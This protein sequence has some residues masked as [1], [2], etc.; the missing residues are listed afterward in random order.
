ML[1]FK[2]AGE[3]KLRENLVMKFGGLFRDGAPGK[4]PRYPMVVYKDGEDAIIVRD[5]EAHEAAKL[6]GFDHITAGQ[7][8]NK[9]LVNWFWD[10]EDL[11]PRQL[12]VFAK[13]EYDVDL[14]V[15][16]GQEKLFQ[17]VCRLTKAAPQNRSRITLMAHSIKMNYD[18]TLEE[19]R[20]MVD[21]TGPD[22][23]IQTEKWEITA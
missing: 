10:L 9:N 18:E 21:A 7:M 20:R 17:C 16:C 8:Q 1:N 2:G 4:R 11:S 19:I 13:D 5:T 6:K 3:A 23:E 12:V 15:E 22:Y 14:P